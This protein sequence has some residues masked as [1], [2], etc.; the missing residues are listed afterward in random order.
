M[1]VERCVAVVP[2]TREAD[3]AEFERRAANRSI[4]VARDSFPPSHQASG[5]LRAN[6]RSKSPNAGIAPAEAMQDGW[7]QRS[8]HIGHIADLTHGGVVALDKFVPREASGTPARRTSPVGTAR[9][10]PGNERN[11]LR[12]RSK[13]SEGADAAGR[14][15]SSP[16]WSGDGSISMPAVAD[17]FD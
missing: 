8:L 1:R 11:A 9:F 4:T 12:V 17:G 10:R 16:P 2:V 7:P 6:L 15:V 14:Q 5:D 3:V 13:C